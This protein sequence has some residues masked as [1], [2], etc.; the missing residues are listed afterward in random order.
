MSADN[1]PSHR[2][3]VGI[4]RVR[5]LQGLESA[6]FRTEICCDKAVQSVRV[7]EVVPQNEAGIAS[8]APLS[9]SDQLFQDIAHCLGV[10][11]V[12]LAYLHQLNTPAPW[13]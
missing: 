4:S 11:R 13:A 5:T 8:F 6:Y 3:P 9:S 10:K 7:L 12:G 2:R 1:S